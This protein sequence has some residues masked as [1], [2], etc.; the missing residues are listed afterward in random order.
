MLQLLEA[1]LLNIS[2]RIN[3]AI[4]TSYYCFNLE[5]FIVQR[6]VIIVKSITL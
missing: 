2:I 1:K 4:H 5:N 3:K 6:F